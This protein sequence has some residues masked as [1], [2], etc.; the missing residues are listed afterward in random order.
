MRSKRVQREIDELVTRGWTIEDESRDRVVM[1]DREFGSVAAHVVI[2]VLTAWWT[3]GLGNVLWAAYNYVANS[4]RRILWERT[5]TCPNCG[6]VVEEDA[7][8]C[9]SCG[10]EVEGDADPLEADSGRESPSA[11]VCPECDAVAARG[12]RF[13]RACGA[14]LVDAAESPSSE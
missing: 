6:T 4:R 7:S 1:V 3:M 9:P 11:I 14:K 12:D 13:C 8:Y 2:A 10:L 5:T